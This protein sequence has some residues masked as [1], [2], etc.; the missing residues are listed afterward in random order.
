MNALT[1]LRFEEED[2]QA[3][4]QGFQLSEGLA[5]APRA[6]SITGFAPGS[7]ELTPPTAFRLKRRKPHVIK[8]WLPALAG[9]CLV[10]I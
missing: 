2:P 7:P 3:I 5:A 4:L 9:G 1:A 10:S 8:V 6:E